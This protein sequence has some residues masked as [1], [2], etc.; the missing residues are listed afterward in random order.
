M[1]TY[2]ASRFLTEKGLFSPLIKLCYSLIENSTST[3]Y[4]SF[5]LL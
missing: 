3:C 2:Q 1:Q 5:I 4:W